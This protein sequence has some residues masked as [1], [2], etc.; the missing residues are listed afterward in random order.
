MSDKARNDF[1]GPGPAGIYRDNLAAGTFALQIC[2]ACG[3]KAVFPPRAICP[4][5]GGTA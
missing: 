2:G 5:C 3:G 4:S 1:S